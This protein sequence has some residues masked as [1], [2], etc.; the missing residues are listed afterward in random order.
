MK[1]GLGKWFGEK[2]VDIKTG[3]PC[4]RS[5]SE[6]SKRGYPACRPSEAAAK[7]SSGQKA[8]MAK[9]KTGPARKSWPISP[10]GK[11]KPV[12]RAHSKLGRP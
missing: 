7:M 8:T 11:S 1:G 9:T 5:G 4:G 6:K 10:S 3:K 2:W 12:A